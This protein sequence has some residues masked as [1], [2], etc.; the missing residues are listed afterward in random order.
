[1]NLSDFVRLPPGVKVAFAVLI[2]P[3]VWATFLIIVSLARDLRRQ[4]D[5]RRPAVSQKAA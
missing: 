2:W 3:A 5:A 4:A 1:M